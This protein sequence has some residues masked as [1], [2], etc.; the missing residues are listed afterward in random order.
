MGWDA[1][2]YKR[3]SE[4]RLVF[5]KVIISLMADR[6]CETTVQIQ[7][8]FFTTKFRKLIGQQFDATAVQHCMLSSLPHR[9]NWCSDEEETACR[10]K[11]LQYDLHIGGNWCSDEAGEEEREEEA[12][13]CPNCRGSV[14]GLS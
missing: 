1:L 10:G 3:V 6:E 5:Q 14:E 9:G 13:C 4:T 7:E 8:V 11:A 2:G 12:G